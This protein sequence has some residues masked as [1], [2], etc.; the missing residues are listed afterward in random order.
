MPDNQAS[1]SFRLRWIRILGDLASRLLG[2]C[3]QV[4]LDGNL[5]NRWR[6]IWIVCGALLLALGGFGWSRHRRGYHPVAVPPE[7]TRMLSA[8]SKRPGGF[9]PRGEGHVVLA[10]PGSRTEEKSYHEPGGSFSPTVGSFGIAIAVA[11]VAGRILETSDT[12]PLQHLNQAFIH[13]EDDDA[14]PLLHS[15]TPYYSATWKTP[16]PGHWT[17]SLS[18]D[19]ARTSELVVVVRSVGPA[20]GPVWKLELKDGALIINERFS[21]SCSPAPTEVRLGEEPDH[22]VEAWLDRDRASSGNVLVSAGGW[23]FARLGWF[24]PLPIEL[25]LTDSLPYPTST[26]LG[27]AHRKIEVSLNQP[28]FEASLAAQ[29]AHLRMSLVGQE[30]RPGEPVNYPLEWLRDGAYVVVALARAGHF[31]LAQLLAQRF[32]E[33]DFFGGFGPEGDNPGFAIWTLDEVSAAS[34]DRAWDSRMYPH[35]IRKARLIEQ[36]MTSS[37]PMHVLPLPSPIV[38]SWIDNPKRWLPLSLVSDPTRDGLIIGRM[39]GH[40]PLL[41]VNAINYLGL[42]RATRFAHRADDAERART[43]QERAD[44]LQAAWVRALQ[45]TER[46]NERTAISG[47]WPSFIA[48]PEKAAYRKL[49]LQRD[50]L[51]LESPGKLK[52][53]NE[54]SYFDVAEMHQWLELGDTERVWKG[55]TG[56]F[57]RQSSPGLYTWGEGTGEENTYGLWTNLRGWAR[58]REVTPHYWTA[59]EMLL[60]QLE[61]LAYSSDSAAQRWVLGGGVLTEWLREPLLVRHVGTAR[62][63]ASWDWDPRSK[64]VNA[65]IV[66]E[67]APVGLGPAFPADTR[68]HVSFAAPASAFAQERTQ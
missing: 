52:W 30:T 60:L 6:S 15:V 42:R 20:G 47:L 40:F 29:L 1:C 43:W 46:E 36:M 19:V 24:P 4:K 26:L 61:M 32:A 41:F 64:T 12:I 10:W 34:R 38:P 18:A 33:R 23:L 63:T 66:G 49:L 65:M 48:A 5:R 68:L 31:E 58:P 28:A 8:M 16:R 11:D 57:A 22:E 39:D 25:T 50:R 35:V 62:G 54:W 55:L 45:S 14:P 7:R 9:W 21:L 2:D 59:A 27:L 17:L 3:S 67:K 37:K 51:R 44:D 13:T 53:P 56:Y